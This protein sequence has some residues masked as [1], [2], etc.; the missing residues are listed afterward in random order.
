MNY[1]ASMLE[2]PAMTDDRQGLTNPVGPAC[3]L[4]A[5]MHCRGIQG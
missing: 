4:K 1:L 5:I 2:L 3:I